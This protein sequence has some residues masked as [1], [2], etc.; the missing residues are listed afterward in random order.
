MAQTAQ[1][2][3]TGPGDTAWLSRLVDA[4]ETISSSHSPCAPIR[5][6]E[7]GAADMAALMAQLGRSRAAY[8]VAG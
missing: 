4:F 7:I 3:E 1:R 6:D 8:A 2:L 5:S